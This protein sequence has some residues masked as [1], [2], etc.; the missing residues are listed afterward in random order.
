MRKRRSKMNNWYF[1]ATS[2]PYGQEEFGPYGSFEE[3]LATI[4]RIQKNI[5]GIG[6]DPIEFDGVDR[7]YHGP[8]LGKDE[9][10]DLDVGI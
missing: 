3:A 5:L 10:G 6:E 4:G 8:Y 1:I 2:A 9:E 7:W